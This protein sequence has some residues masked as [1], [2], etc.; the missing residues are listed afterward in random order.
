MR[1]KKITAVILTVLLLLPNCIPAAD[2]PETHSGFV[3]ETAFLKAVGVLNETFRPASE[4]S[5]AEFVTM[6]IKT[7]YP[8]SDFSAAY[9][10]DSYIFK[11]VDRRHEA[12][13]YIKACK[14]L[15]IINGN[16]EG[17]FY[18]DQAVSMNE[19]I[20]ILV[21]ALGYTRHAIAY[22][23]YPTGYLSI[24]M[25][26]GILKGIDVSS[27]VNGAL[28]AKLLYN[29][30]F[31]DLVGVESINE[32]GVS[33]RIDSS[34]NLLSERL[35]IKEYDVQLTDNG[36]TSLTGDSIG[37]DERVVFTDFSTMEQ[38]T[39]YI[40]DSKVTEYL[41][42]RLKVFIRYN[43]ESGRDELVYFTPHRN[44]RE[45]TL[46][47][48]QVIASNKNT[49]EYEEE[50]N[51]D[52]TK[53]ISFASSGPA[54]VL[55]G[56]RITNQTLDELLPKDGLLHAVD[57]EGDGRYDF[58]EIFS[59][60]I[61]S[62]EK[63]DMARNLVSDSIGA[64]G[65]SIRCLFNPA[66]SLDL[67]S[68][69]ASYRIVHSDIDSLDQLLKHDIVSVAEAPE[70]IDGKTF[71][72]LLI[73]QNSVQGTAD[74]VSP[75]NNE[76]SVGNKTY[77]VSSSLTGV[78]PKYLDHIA[79]DQEMDFMLDVQGKIAYIVNYASS[80]KNYGY[81]IGAM[82]EEGIE[83]CVKV[84][85]FTKEG[86]VITAPIASKATIDG[87]RCEGRQQI[88]EALKKRPSGSTPIAGAPSY[89]SYVERPVLYHINA[90]GEI[91]KLDTDTPN[92]ESGE[93]THYT[94]ET[95]IPYSKAEA[96][97]DD[98]LK[99]G[100]RS[101]RAAPITRTAFS[102]ESRFYITSDTVILHVPGIDCY[103]MDRFRD[104]LTAKNDNNLKGTEISYEM[105][106]LY[107]QER[108]D[109]NY[110][111]LTSSDLNTTKAYD[112]QAYD[113]D[114]ATGVASLVVLRG[115][116]DPYYYQG[117]PRDSSLPMSIFVKKT[118]I[119]DEASQKMLTNLYYT[120]DGVNI[121]NVWVDTDTLLFSYR[122]IIEGCE[123]E[124]TPY[125]S[126]VPG[127]VPGDVIRV[128]K[129]G[130]YLSHIDRPFRYGELRTSAYTVSNMPTNTKMMYSTTLY[131]MRKPGVP[132][133][134]RNAAAGFNDGYYMALCLPEQVK[135]GMV[136]GY[137]GAE[138]VSDILNR[139]SGEYVLDLSDPSKYTQ[140]YF[141]IT[142][143]NI[144]LVE[145]NKQGELKTKKGSFADIKTVN[146]PGGPE[147]A[148]LMIVY[149]TYA[150]VEQVIVIN[151]ERI[152]G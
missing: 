118:Q 14:D 90:D 141:N 49:I 53:K 59:F 78:Q 65:D 75:A 67:S 25:Q 105:V 116:L 29:A 91:N 83:D 151:D 104:Y 76:I 135:N 136:R 40:N 127:L 5:K 100:Y 26:S 58:L 95:F 99:A 46:P 42:S 22:G 138:H 110:Q 41:G 68:D 19:A 96:E 108:I 38:I 66:G 81:L 152:G 149:T 12:F 3:Q 64:D 133:D 6:I 44:S 39:A 92:E 71:Y 94:S 130:K 31:A 61:Y 18:P 132:N 36:I 80:S 85:L 7:L 148:S 88:M 89:D 114:E 113:I 79:F 107:E 16:P 51:A 93:R 124:A 70:P 86:Q 48:Y 34:K 15:N 128:L 140:Q 8:D 50:K 109:E 63:L 55:N 112:I 9:D 84:K 37:S 101:L 142:G 1:K 143:K 119:Y 97:S 121:E 57:L 122:Y 82:E 45:I 52:K 87:A 28:A 103:G 134:Q 21:N 145:F 30:L 43:K 102:I 123:E 62:G 24:A 106:Q 69:T 54:I 35:G 2:E 98:A 23:G 150:S 17:Y 4:M 13:A 111:V 126:A 131:G 60:N 137:L 120:S 147:K 32:T 27:T 74:Y 20:V 144:L 129:E 125:G 77:E 139:T 72:F 56:I 11:D 115:S 10:Y 47:A 33:I 146:E 73:S 117:A